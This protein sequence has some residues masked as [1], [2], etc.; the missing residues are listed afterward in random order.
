MNYIIDQLKAL[1]AIDS[2]SGFTEDVTRYTMEQFE[3]LGYHPYRTKKGCVVCD[4]GG[5]GSPLIL[6]AHIDTLGGMVAEIKK[7]GRLRITNIGG[8][9]ANNCETEN[10]RIRTRSGKVFEG[11]LQMND[12][13]V[14]VN[15]EYSK[16]N[17]TFADMEIVIDE[18]VKEK[19]DTETLGICNGDFVCF[20]PRT[21]ITKSGYIKSRFLDDKLSVAILLGLAR[22]L[23]KKKLKLKRKVYVFITV[24]EE[25][26]HGACGA[27]PAD[28]EEI[29]SVDMGCIGE[30]LACT[31]RMVSICAKDSHGPY[32]YEVT[33]NL[34]RCAQEGKLD[35]A[36]DVYPYY[37]SDADA[38]LA[39]GYDLKHGL[40][41]AGVYASHG[42]ERS[43]IDGV[44]N[45][46]KLLEL[47]IKKK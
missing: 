25:V 24:Y 6:S 19:K 22:D 29:I 41:G 12:P 36:V 26:G 39:A 10:C 4:L 11:T 34:I 33:T 5:E 9:N 45:T 1:T 18:D 31:E 30:G 17:R 47:Y 21:T 43:H 40:I 2:P 7:N 27:L 32:D 46:L 44:K 37:G 38:A 28:A 15:D 42:Y 13:S 8:L 20:D 23:Q 35:F 16:Q 14:H 3:S